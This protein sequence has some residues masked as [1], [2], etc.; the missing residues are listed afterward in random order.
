MNTNVEPAAAATGSPATKSRPRKPA[1]DR[2]TAKRL[3]AAEYARVVE[4]LESL[5]ASQW[6]TPTCNSGWDVRDLVAHMTGMTAMAASVPEQMRQMRAAKKRHRTG[7]LIDSLTA[8]QV[9]K[10]AS[11]DPARLVTEYARLAPKAVKGRSR[12]PGLMRGRTLPGEQAIDPGRIYEL[13][14]FSYLVDVILT[15]DPWM[16]RSDITAATGAE[17]ALS[18]NHDGVIVGDV[19]TEWAHRHGQPCSL[20]LTGPAGGSWTFGDHGPSYELDAVE[21]C[22]ILSG[23]GTGEGLLTT[24]VPF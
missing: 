14:T 11:W 7:D 4:Q 2:E 15:R 17:L 8:V 23:R 5:S 9:E 18:A 10:Y 1:F 13:W 20:V 22:R 12:M 24:R 16:H 21:F 3:M 6:S 19:V